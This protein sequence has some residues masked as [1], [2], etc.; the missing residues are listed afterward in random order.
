[1]E[2]LSAVAVSALTLYDMCK[3]VDRGMTIKQIQLE[4]KSGGT[5]GDWSRANA[6]SPAAN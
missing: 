1:M 3:S 2:A 6:Q 5:S 4:T